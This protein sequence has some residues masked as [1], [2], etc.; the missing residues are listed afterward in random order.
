MFK[1]I[2]V[3]VLIIFLFSLFQISSYADDNISF[4][5][6]YD[7]E[8]YLDIANNAY[9]KPKK[10]LIDKANFENITINKTKFDKKVKKPALFYI[11]SDEI[12][13]VLI[14][15]PYGFTGSLRKINMYSGIGLTKV[16]YQT[17]SQNFDNL[18][19]TFKDVDGNFIIIHPEIIHFNYHY[20]EHGP[21]ISDV[22]TYVD[23]TMLI[24]VYNNNKE[25]FHKIYKVNNI[26]TYGNRGKTTND[27]LS[28]LI[29][30]AMN[31][32]YQKN[33]Q[34]ILEKF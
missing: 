9:S 7:Q 19:V 5:T 1:K 8:I 16:G 13:N 15:A 31:N 34:D 23:L 30:T 29:A 3:F 6:P 32:I 27:I 2:K 12:S 25:I 24:T 10:R 21:I 26:E 28:N 11:D 14:Q 18:K 22:H 17:Y 20:E 4:F 33:L